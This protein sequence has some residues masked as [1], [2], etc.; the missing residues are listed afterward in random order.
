[1]T[2]VRRAV[3]FWVSAAIIAVPARCQEA[4]SDEGTLTV[5]ITDTFGSRVPPG[6]LSVRSAG[7]EI[8]SSAEVQSQAVVRLAY[9]RY[10]IEFRSNWYQPARRDVVINSAESFAELG[11]VFVA[12]EENYAPGSIS[13]KVD[14]ANS[15]SAKGGAS[16][17][18]KLVGVYTQ[19]TE[20]RHI[21]PRGFALFEPVDRGTY[22]VIVVEGSK[23]RAARPVV[24]KGQV[25]VATV[26]IPPCESE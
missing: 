20:E 14:P 2:S 3:L 5:D 22:L 24:A 7:G 10:T 19:Y 15:C 26:S 21:S 9:G 13:V 18:A 17:R 12:P 8:V 4:K 23:V 25:T 1:V 16:L 11:A 6:M